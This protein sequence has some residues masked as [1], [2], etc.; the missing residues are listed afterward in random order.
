V[1]EPLDAF[2]GALRIA[3]ALEAAGTPYAIGGAIA[4]ALWGPPRG[5]L[6]IDLNVFVEPEAL[7]GVVEVL[8]PLGVVFDHADVVGEAQARGMVMGRLGVFRG[9]DVVDLERLVAM[10]GSR[11]DAANVR[12]HVAEMM[13]E[14]D[15]RVRTWDRLTRA[16]IAT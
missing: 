14:D 3:A 2:D 8:R 6:D 1:G 15:E 13:G 4:Y 16:A 7:P 11:L 12:R 9:K 5:T 10:Q